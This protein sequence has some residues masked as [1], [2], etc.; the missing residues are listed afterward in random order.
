M[1]RGGLGDEDDFFA[2]IEPSSGVSPGFS[3]NK[4]SG[5]VRK[6]PSGISPS[7]PSKGS[8]VKVIKGMSLPGAPAAKR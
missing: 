7:S 3:K 1:V 5:S 6:P 2:G 4:P 8:G